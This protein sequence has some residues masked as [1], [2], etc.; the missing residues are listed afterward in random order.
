VA[1]DTGDGEAGRLVVRFE[2]LEGLAVAAPRDPAED[3]IHAGD[4][5]VDA[6]LLR[7]SPALLVARIEDLGQLDALVAAGPAAY[8]WAPASGPAALRSRS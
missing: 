7:L 4:C 1:L 5:V 6:D 3:S 8:G 2:L